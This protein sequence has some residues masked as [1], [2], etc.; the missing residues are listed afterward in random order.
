MDAAVH[1]FL[2]SLPLHALDPKLLLPLTKHHLRFFQGR[3]G[4][5]LEDEI[6]THSILSKARKR[7]GAQVFERLFARSVEQCVA[8]AWSMAASCILMPANASRNSVIEV[9]V[10]REVSK[11]EEQEQ[12]ED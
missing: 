9:V 12:E 10:R 8:A 2:A 4:Y 7:W 6:P 3:L 11:L 5:G 1:P